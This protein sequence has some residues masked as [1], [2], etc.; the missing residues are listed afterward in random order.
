MRNV[1]AIAI[2]L[3]GVAMFSGCGNDDKDKDNNKNNGKT[4]DCA[5]ITW[6]SL[7]KAA[8]DGGIYKV[9]NDYTPE[10]WGDAIECFTILYKDKYNSTVHNVVL[11]YKDKAAADAWAKRELDSGTKIPIQNCNFLTFAKAIAGE[12]RDEREKEFL[13]DFINGRPFNK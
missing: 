9:E 1:V 10:P 3:A 5:T 4:N 13:E 8:Q 2:C 6:A 12:L 7:K 11:R